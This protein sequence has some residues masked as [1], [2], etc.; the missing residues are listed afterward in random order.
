MKAGKILKSFIGMIFLMNFPIWVLASQGKP[1]GNVKVS[2]IAVNLI[3]SDT[4]PSPKKNTETSTD[5]PVETAI[6]EVPKAHRQ[7][8]PVPVIKVKPIKI[9]KPKIKIIKPVINV[10]H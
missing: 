10:L 7:V 5:K 2:S 1:V 3:L 8:V 4:I 6:K 9:I